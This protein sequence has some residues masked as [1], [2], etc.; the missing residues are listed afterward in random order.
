MEKAV[1]ALAPAKINLH[2]R[3]YGR[4]RDGFHGLRSIFQAVSLADEIIV[5]SLKETERIEI[6][7]VFDCPPEKTTFYKAAQAFRRTTGERG[8]ISVSVTKS[9][10]QGAGLGGGSSDAAAFL[11]AL[12]GLFETRLDEVTLARLGAEVGSD[13][14]FFLKGG[15]ALVTGRG[16]TVEALEPREDFFGLVVFPGFPVSTAGAFALLDRERPDDRDEADPTSEELSLAYRMRPSAWPFAN[17]FEPHV[18]RA[19]PEI[20]W[21]REALLGEG[22]AFAGMTGSGSTI[23]GIFDDADRVRSAKAAL[24]GRGRGNFLMASIIPLA[25]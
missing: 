13:V 12:D 5:R 15:A 19:H 4:R 2:L 22:A 6:D 7:G 18:G 10:P 16:E 3:V 25:P 14:P 17:S 9:I 1:R 23:F 11:R 8:G 24:E 20:P 21:W